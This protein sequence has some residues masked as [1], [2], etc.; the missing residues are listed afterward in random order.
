MKVIGFIDAMEPGEPIRVLA[1][2]CVLKTEEGGK[3][4]PFTKGYRPNHNFGEA[5]ESQFYVGQ[6]EVP[7]D[8]WIKPGETHDLRIT[9]LHEPGL[10]EL[11]QPGRIWR[12]QEGS[13]LVA[14]G[15]VLSRQQSEA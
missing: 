3:A 9:F 14:M 8:T 12:I 2:V 7:E 15:Q 13:K 6:I 1:R 4:Q 11:L 5:Q 10:G